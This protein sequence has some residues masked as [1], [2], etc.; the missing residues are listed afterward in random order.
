MT[1]GG[2]E[3]ALLGLVVLGGCQYDPYTHSYATQKP[4]PAEIV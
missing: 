3:W 4:N 2:R 1:A